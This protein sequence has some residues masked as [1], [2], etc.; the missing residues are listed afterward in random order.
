MVVISQALEIVIGLAILILLVMFFF[1]IFGT[2][3]CNAFANTTAVQLKQAIDKVAL[4]NGVAPWP[5]DD[6]PPDEK[7]EYY[8]AVP[9]RLCEQRGDA[10]KAALWGHLPTHE[11]VYETFPQSAGAWMESTPFGGGAMS[12]LMFYGALKIAPKAI[13]WGR[14][15]AG[16]GT[17]FIKGAIKVINPLEWA[18]HIG[19]LRRALDYVRRSRAYKWF[20]RRFSA[21]SRLRSVLD[22]VPDRFNYRYFSKKWKNVA[23]SL[24]NSRARNF[25]DEVQ[26][27]ADLGIIKAK[28]DDVT[29]KWIPELTE[30]AGETKLVVNHQ[31]RGFMKRFIDLA[32]DEAEKAF[33]KSIYHVPNF[34]ERIE[35]IKLNYWYPAKDWVSTV[36]KN[37]KIN[38]YFVEPINNFRDRAKNTWNRFFNRKEY[39]GHKDLPQKAGVWKK[40]G[41]LNFDDYRKQVLNNFD[42]FR[43]PLEELTG[44]VLNNVD[45]VAD[46]DLFKFLANYDRY[47]NAVPFAQFRVRGEDILTQSYET[48]G[49]FIQR[50]AQEV[51]DSANPQAAYSSFQNLFKKQWKD[52]TIPERETWMRMLVEGHGV[53]I[54]TL[55]V[56][57]AKIIYEDVRADLIKK[58]MLDINNL[59]KGGNF[60]SSRFLSQADRVK[61]NMFWGVVRRNEFRNFDEFKDAVPKF[62]LRPVVTGSAVETL[63]DVTFGFAL[64]RFKQTVMLDLPRAGIGPFAQYNP[65]PNP[66]S[67]QESLRRATEIMEGGCAENSIC[68]IERGVPGGPTEGATAYLLDR[69]V[70]EDIEVKLWRPK[71]NTLARTPIYL[72]TAMFYFSVPE[73]PR[74]HLISPCYGIA[75]IW[76]KDNTVYVNIEKTKKCDVGDPYCD[77][78]TPN[79]CYA[80]EELI[81]GENAY[82]KG[83]MIT[84]GDAP[85]EWLY[86]GGFA[87]CSIACSA[88]SLAA[89][90]Q[91]CLKGCGYAAIG[92]LFAHTTAATV[93][94][95][96]SSWTRQRTGW[97]YWNYQKAGDIC[98]ILETA[99][100]IGSWKLGKGVTEG[101]SRN[102]FVRG[103]NKFTNNKYVK[104]VGKWGGEKLGFG[105]GDICYGLLLIGDTSLSWP[106]KV[107]VGQ[108]L[109]KN[110]PLTAECMEEASGECAW[111][112]KEVG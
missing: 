70:P 97:G 109:A 53:D 1:N 24:K 11:I 55:G 33:Y 94:Y 12:S 82:N 39:I 67:T 84:T 108:V 45:D 100:S 87:A 65:V 13:S 8:A 43:G 107:P 23:T 16:Y 32:D 81:W 104:K 34:F 66:Y 25:V 31:Y 29:G 9:I 26:A 50:Q 28:W 30:I 112:E 42:E 7:G 19:R 103:L 71:P 15:L 101:V 59:M 91:G 17:K 18:T 74:F 88:F 38:R 40:W 64:P 69:A 48:A 78:N 106:I 52:L 60:R 102:R 96:G 4:E 20:A 80:D 92:S 83:N 63:E 77:S 89:G 41:Y 10:W 86:L 75:K 79:Y 47:Y 46:E 14:T 5:G 99:T 98:D 95:Q 93:A 111:I 61:G 85:S 22:S 56:T 110:T 62:W 49:S 35:K 44:K 58:G 37:S 54:S 68:K 21:S 73:H 2:P 76:K 6:V 51:V 72:S 27:L 36:W 90:A 105:I 3:E 57:N